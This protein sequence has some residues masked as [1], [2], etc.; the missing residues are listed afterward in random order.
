MT[1]LNPS[2]HRTVL[3][4]DDEAVI[5]IKL[6]RRIGYVEIR[7][8]GV[9]GPTGYPVIGVDV[10]SKTRATPAADGRLYEPRFDRDCAVVLIGRPGPRMLEQQRQLAWF[11]KAIRLHDSGDH[12]ECPDTCPAKT[13]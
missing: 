6:P 7:T 12:T 4:H 8:D 3:M 1:E 2:E 11:E 9:N 10:V 13:A 5:K